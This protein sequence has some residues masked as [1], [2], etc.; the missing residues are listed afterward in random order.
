MS[1]NACSVGTLTND[2]NNCHKKSFTKKLGLIFIESLTE[3]EKECLLWRSNLRRLDASQNSNPTVC[4]HHK[5]LFLS[6]FTRKQMPCCDLFGLHESGSK[7]KGVAIISVEAA[8]NLENKYSAVKP[9]L[10]LCPNCFKHS[11]TIC[12]LSDSSESENEAAFVL[13]TEEIA[14]RSK[15]NLTSVLDVVGGSPLK[16][17]GLDVRKKWKACKRKIETV[18]KQLIADLSV[19]S[20]LDQSFLMDDEEEP[21]EAK[22]ARQDCEDYNSML[23]ALKSNFSET[24]ISYD[25][26]I[27]ILIVLPESRSRTKVV[28]FFGNKY[29]SEYAA[30]KAI[31]VRKNHGILGK[32]EQ[33]K[34]IG[35]TDEVKQMVRDIYEDDEVS[36]TLPGTKDQVSLGNKV[37][38][39]KRLLL[40]TVKELYNHFV[41]KYPEVKIKLTLY[42]LKPKWCIQPGKS[43]THSVCVC[44]IH[45]NVAL[46]CDAIDKKHNELLQRLVCDTENKI[47]MVHRC[48]N[49][50][51][52][53]G[54]L[55]KFMEMF[56]DM[57]DEEPI[58]FQQ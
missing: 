10:K 36:R 21:L 13:M 25:K 56:S 18:T 38:A 51:G 40:C 26:K 3:T 41:S 47:C 22:R 6:K 31:E 24:N 12:N 19:A 2:S 20:N 39:Q 37:Y 29:C 52:I 4:H 42:S 48:Q 58:H 57:D 9:G 17:H 5:L 1:L 54:L 23:N 11:K 55:N 49:C 16:L 32:S 50:P 53:D 7:A 28:N 15:S 35:I 46:L 33:K 44:A 8:K 43:G 34:R 27:Q 14:S 45:Q 30:R